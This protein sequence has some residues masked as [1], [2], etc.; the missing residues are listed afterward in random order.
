MQLVGPFLS[1][2]VHGNSPL[3]ILLRFIIFPM[4]FIQYDFQKI[5]ILVFWLFSS[6]IH[7]FALHLITYF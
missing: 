2:S 4:G 3:F 7:Y 5:L 1:V 6:N